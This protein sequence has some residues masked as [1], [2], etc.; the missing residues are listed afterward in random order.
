MAARAGVGVVDRPGMEG[1]MLCP[2]DLRH[3]DGGVRSRS[4]R[5]CDDGT[6]RETFVG[7]TDGEDAGVVDRVEAGVGARVDPAE[8]G[9]GKK[10]DFLVG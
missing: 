7:E 3:A 1:G 8:D 10:P 9:L 6:I 4:E 5:P 2:K